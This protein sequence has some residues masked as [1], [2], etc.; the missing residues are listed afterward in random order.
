MNERA[1]PNYTLRVSWCT[2][3]IQGCRHFVQLFKW[4]DQRGNHRLA[5][6]HRRFNCKFH[7]RQ[8]PLSQIHC[9]ERVDEWMNGWMTERVKQCNQLTQLNI[10]LK[11]HRGKLSK[12]ELHL[13]PKSIT[14]DHSLAIWLLVNAPRLAFPRLQ[15]NMHLSIT[16][17]LL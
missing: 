17:S 12:Y 15:P 3:D 2:D 16:I 11:V 10:D 1:R 5:F 8:R 7:F 9:S 13:L 14:I 6:S 4:I